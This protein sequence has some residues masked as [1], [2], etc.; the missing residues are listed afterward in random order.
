MAFMSKW[1]ASMKIW[2]GERLWGYHFSQQPAQML[3]FCGDTVAEIDFMEKSFQL[4]ITIQEMRYEDG[5]GT[6]ISSGSFRVHLAIKVLSINIS[7]IQ[8]N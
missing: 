1:G 5:F 7:M 8:L 3:Q 2:M 6:G 4:P